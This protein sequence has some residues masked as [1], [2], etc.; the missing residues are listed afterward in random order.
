[1]ENKVRIALCDDEML[2]LPHLSAEIKNALFEKNY[3]P[4]IITFTSA[5][6]LLNYLY[7]GFEN[8][9]YFLDIDL[10]EQDGITLA[11]KIH[12]RQ[13]DAIIIYL[14]A[15]ED[16]VFDTFPTQPLAFIRKSSFRKDLQA[17]VN[18][19]TEH[20][21]PSKDTLISFRDDLDHDISVNLTRLQYVQAKEKYQQF[22]FIDNSLLIRC[23]IQRVEDALS[24]YGFIRIH[25]CFI[26]NYQYI[27]RINQ[28][29][30]TLDSGFKLPVSRNRKK[31]VSSQ[32]MSLS[33]R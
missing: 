1:M 28:N 7:S 5:R 9:V 12:I 13:P 19:L 22:V 18:V 17:A 24:S 14:S 4:E 27:Y 15:R 29:S 23:S 20:L 33:M 25:R 31:E 2:I 21:R 32:Y 6:E 11:K 16:L 26:V 8:D 10:P 30:I 3:R